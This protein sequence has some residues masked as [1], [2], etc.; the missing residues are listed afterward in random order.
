[1]YRRG[2]SGVR[3]CRRLGSWCHVERREL[4]EGATRDFSSPDRVGDNDYL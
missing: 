3:A 4:R 1:M 2:S